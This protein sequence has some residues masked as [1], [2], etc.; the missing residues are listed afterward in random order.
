MFSSQVL[1]SKWS[2]RHPEVI[3]PETIRSCES[4]PLIFVYEDIYT[5]YTCTSCHCDFPSDSMTVC[6]CSRSCWSLSK[7]HC[8]QRVCRWCINVPF[9]WQYSECLY[10]G[11]YVNEAFAIDQHLVQLHSSGQE[12]HKSLQFSWICMRVG[13]DACQYHFLCLAAFVLYIFVRLCSIFCTTRKEK[14]GGGGGE[15]AALLSD[16]EQHYNR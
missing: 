13:K 10:D 11:L 8:C 12:T 1:K 14:K 6:C 16:R 4:A 9:S 5:A 15:R 7:C 3:R 2:P